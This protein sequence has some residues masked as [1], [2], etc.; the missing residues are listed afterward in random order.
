MNRRRILIWGI[1]AFLY[2]VF[3][4]WYTDFGGPLREDEMAMYL[5]RFEELG[6]SEERRERIGRFMKSDTGRQFLMVNIVDYAEDP[7]DVDGAEPG[8]S[9]SQLMKRY[10]EHMFAELFARACHPTVMGEAVFR[11][12]DL[13]GVDALKSADRWDMGALFRYRSRRTFLEIVTMPETMERHH[14]KVAALEKTIAYPIETQLNLGDPR[15]S[16]GLLLLV[17]AALGDLFLGRGRS[18]P[19]AD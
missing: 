4:G 8:E 14:F 5:T 6:F 2:V 1:P 16:L 11:A 13:V 10:M 18:G 3:V 12:L 9:A 15:F 17:I 7:P 19:S